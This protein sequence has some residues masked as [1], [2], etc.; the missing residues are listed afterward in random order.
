MNSL[1]VVASGPQ[2]TVKSIY[3]CGARK[4]R[5]GEEGL[6]CCASCPSSPSSRFVIAASLFVFLRSDVACPTWA[7]PGGGGV[8]PPTSP[9][10][11]RLGAMPPP[12]RSSPGWRVLFSHSEVV[13]VYPPLQDEPLTTLQK[14]LKKKLGD[15]AYPF[16]LQVRRTA[17]FVLASRRRPRRPPFCPPPCLASSRQRAPRPPSPSDRCTTAARKR[18]PCVASSGPSSSLWPTRPRTGAVHGG[19]GQRRARPLAVQ[20]SAQ[21]KKNR[22]ALTSTRS[23]RLPGAPSTLAFASCRTPPRHT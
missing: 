9:S 16:M 2:P 20:R 12:R 19:C 13:Q 10:P 3:R 8:A 17:P 15:N 14:K 4:E 6:S 22:H 5:R 18:R 11:R 21:Q 1:D 23:L 7:G